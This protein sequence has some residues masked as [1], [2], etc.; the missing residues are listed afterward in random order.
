MGDAS[1]FD[2]MLPQALQQVGEDNAE[3]IAPP[4]LL[5]LGPFLLALLAE[6]FM[7]TRLLD[8]MA[9]WTLGAAF[10]AAWALL[11]GWAVLAMRRAGTTP[12]P[13]R[14]TTAIVETGPYRF[15]RNP[16]YVGFALATIGLAVLFDTA[17]GFVALVVGL[18][19]TR[20]GVIAREERYLERTFSAP[21]AAYKRR[22]RRWL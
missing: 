18:L 16:M 13:A 12:L 4:P 11:Q 21:Y 17:W 6:R 9:R 8:G 5:F 20:H 3:V 22:V 19:L 15:T 14:P 10:V 7:T 2:R 1:T